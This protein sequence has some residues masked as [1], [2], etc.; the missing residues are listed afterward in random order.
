MLAEILEEIIPGGYTVGK[1]FSVKVE[2]WNFKWLVI[3][4][5]NMLT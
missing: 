2:K 1:F 5:H 4:W 3:K